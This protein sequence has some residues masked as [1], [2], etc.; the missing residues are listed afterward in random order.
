M[1]AS[2]KVL[3]SIERFSWLDKVQWQ[4]HVSVMQI[5]G[6]QPDTILSLKAVFWNWR[7]RDQ[8]VMA[9]MG[10]EE[11]GRGGNYYNTS[12]FFKASSQSASS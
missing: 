12:I 11:V 4:E 8:G 1:L 5:D 6:H 7:N 10:R 9:F 2:K 3:R